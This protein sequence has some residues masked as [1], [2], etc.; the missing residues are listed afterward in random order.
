MRIPFSNLD[1]SRNYISKLMR[2]ATLLE[3]EN[4]LSELN[5]FVAAALDCFELSIEYGTYNLTNP[6]SVTT[7]E[8]VALIQ[9]CGVSDKEFKFFQSESEFMQLA[10]KTPRS[11][12]VLDSSK[13]LAAGLRLT[14][15]REALK[16]ALEQWVREESGEQRVASGRKRVRQ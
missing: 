14:S 6:G 13:A 10:A 5:E 8:V 2:Y 12:C 15:I 7:S 4:S 1:S 9:E 3:A 11:N 16:R